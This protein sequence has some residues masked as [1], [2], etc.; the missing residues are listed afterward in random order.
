[1][2]WMF[3]CCGIAWFG[4]GVVGRRRWR[5]CRVSASSSGTTLEQQ[6][7]A[8]VWGVCFRVGRRSKRGGGEA[9]GWVGWAF[10]CCGLA[11][12]G[13][14]GVGRGS[15]VM[16]GALELLSW[17]WLVPQSPP[18]AMSCAGDR[19][20][21]SDRL[22]GPLSA[23]G[24]DYCRPLTERCA[25]LPSC[26][27]CRCCREGGAEGQGGGGE[28]GAGRGNQGREL[29]PPAAPVAP[30]GAVLLPALP[31][32]RASTA[33]RDGAASPSSPVRGGS[34]PCALCETAS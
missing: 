3:H 12:F 22:E 10:R 31:A 16:L 4:V 14:G 15:W 33:A 26:C 9:A 21:A 28:E 30:A 17:V 18:A 34:I 25:V 11:C 32:A 24:P 19:A 27:R 13:V 5:G 20:V 7:Q 1:M 8:W 29:C 23:A 2:G 6:V